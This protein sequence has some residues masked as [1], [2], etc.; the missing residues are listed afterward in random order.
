MN[1][2][3]YY[4]HLKAFGLPKHKESNSDYLNRYHNWLITIGYVKA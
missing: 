3:V 4:S 2:L 1:D